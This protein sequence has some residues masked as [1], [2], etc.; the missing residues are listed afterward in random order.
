MSII[1]SI[2]WFPH[3]TKRFLIRLFS[4]RLLRRWR[5]RVVKLGNEIIVSSVELKGQP[6]S[7]WAKAM[8][9]TFVSWTA[10]FFTLNFIFLAFVGGFDHLQVYGRQLVMWVI[11]LISPT[12]GSSGVAELAL[13]AFFSY[14]LPVGMLALVALIW[15]LLTYFPYLFVGTIVLPGWLRRT[16]KRVAKAR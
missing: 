15:R 9:A 13:S 4:F 2:L 5:K 1:A 14:L 10:R 12:P 3:K 16:S 6:I 8:G 11:M 7:Y